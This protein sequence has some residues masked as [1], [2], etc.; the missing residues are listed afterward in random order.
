M[1]PDISR[2]PTTEEM[3]TEYQINAHVYETIFDEWR[4]KTGHLAKIMSHVIA[5]VHIGIISIVMLEVKKRHHEGYSDEQ[6]AMEVNVYAQLLRVYLDPQPRKHSD[7]GEMP[8][9]EEDSKAKTGSI[10]GNK[11]KGSK[12]CPCKGRFHP[13][14]P[15]DCAYVQAALTGKISTHIKAN[16][17]EKIMK[18]RAELDKP[19][20]SKVK[21]KVLE[22]SDISVSHSDQNNNS[23]S[24]ADEHDVPVIFDPRPWFMSNESVVMSAQGKRH[25]PLA[26][27]T[28]L[29]TSA[30]VH[31]VNSKDLLEEGSFVPSEGTS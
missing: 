21:A 7:Y 5:T 2:P 26:H 11:P 15:E 29:A 31:A 13:W 6:G 30:S 12:N 8:I 18:T 3:N 14:Q 10:K 20:W 27:S 17:E 23:G 9:P 22:N 16:S 24:P 19:H 4:F 1:L 25:H 28:I